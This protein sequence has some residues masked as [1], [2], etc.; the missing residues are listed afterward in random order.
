MS[1][2]S[3]IVTPPACVG[4][5]FGA[6]YSAWGGSGILE[7]RNQTLR[8]FYAIFGLSNVHRA[9]DVA[10]FEIQI[11]TQLGSGMTMSTNST[12]LLFDRRMTLRTV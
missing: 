1:D 6:E 8:V 4:L 2:I 3:E 7:M 9:F 10:D 11:A 5:L 12:G